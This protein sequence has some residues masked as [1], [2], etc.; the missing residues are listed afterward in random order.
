MK[1]TPM[2]EMFSGVISLTDIEITTSVI[3]CK[4]ITIIII[5]S[6]FLLFSLH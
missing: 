3:F 2:S 5:P 1:E 4:S 6:K